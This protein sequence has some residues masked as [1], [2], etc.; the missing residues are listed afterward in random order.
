V[1]RI[2]LLVVCCV[3]AGC[4]GVGPPDDADRPTTT[5][6]T[7]T[8]SATTATTTATATATETSTPT[9]T[10]V[11]FGT[12]TADSQIRV[13]NGNHSVARTVTVAVRDAN[14]TL[15]VERSRR[16]PADSTRG[17][18]VD[19]AEP[20]GNYSVAVTVDGRPWDTCRWDRQY[21]GEFLLIQLFT[22]GDV[23]CS[24]AV[25]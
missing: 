3:I 20:A 21:H 9:S 15:V 10:E 4:L 11:S 25:T 7:T 22:D 12:S 18:D 2:A 17:F 24:S 13:H 1:R 14:E 6:T 23:G 19:A 16:I 5:V 8:A